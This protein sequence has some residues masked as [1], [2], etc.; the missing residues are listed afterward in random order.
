MSQVTSPTMIIHG[1]KDVLIPCRHGEALYS[2]CPTRKLFVNPAA[3]EHNTNLTTDITYLIM[4][5]FR[6]FAL[7]DYSFTDLEVPAWAYDKRRSPLYVR[8]VQQVVSHGHMP[9]SAGKHGGNI[10][11]P[12][13]DDDDVPQGQGQPLQREG[14]DAAVRMPGPMKPERPVNLSTVGRASPGD[15]PAADL[16]IPAAA[17]AAATTDRHRFAQQATTVAGR[18][19]SRKCEDSVGDAGQWREPSADDLSPDEPPRM[20][21]SPSKLD[22]GVSTAVSAGAPSVVKRGV[23][24]DAEQLQL[25]L[26]GASFGAAGGAKPLRPVALNDAEL[27]PRLFCKDGDGWPSNRPGGFGDDVDGGVTHIATA[28]AANLAEEMSAEARSGPLSGGASAADKRLAEALRATGRGAAKK[29]L[30]RRGAGGL[31]TCCSRVP[32]DD[33]P[34]I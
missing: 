26:R 18:T 32:L 34:G 21:F 5:M 2:A 7:P 17:V 10:L 9:P 11:I 19:V 30:P 13:G 1:R 20:G 28:V 14:S 8:P 22:H 27:S 23:G 12:D 29:P 33:G 6:F 31:F 16:E 24:E 3:M 25:R 15:Q 4:P